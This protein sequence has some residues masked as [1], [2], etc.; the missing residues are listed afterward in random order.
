VASAATVSILRVG[1]HD[2]VTTLTGEPWQ[3]S[4][5][6]GERPGLG[7]IAEHY[8]V[9]MIGRLRRRGGPPERQAS[10]RARQEEQREQRRLLWGG[11]VDADRVL[12]FSDAV[13]AIAITLLTIELGVRPG[14]DGS[15]FTTELRDLLPALGAYALSFIILGQLWLTHHRIFSVIARVDRPLLICNLAFLGLIAL[16]PFPV[17]LLSDYHDRPLAVAVYALTFIA[18]MLLQGWLWRY[19]TKPERRHLLSE[20]VSDYV[21]QGFTRT[22]SGTLLAFGAVVPLVIWAPRFAAALWA[23]ML[24]VQLVVAWLNR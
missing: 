18:A 21:R 17:R 9:G 5:G 10:R 8:A 16:M 1:H 6:N 2:P 24:V 12:A 11:P 14:L 3:E 22:I 4:A 19:V 7:G 15:A 23:V 13:F 20:P